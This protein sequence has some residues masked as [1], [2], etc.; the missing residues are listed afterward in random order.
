MNSNK[1]R[2]LRR[3]PSL[4]AAPDA[5][6]RHTPKECIKGRLRLKLA[7]DRSR[8]HLNSVTRRVSWRTTHPGL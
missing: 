7:E 3:R 5:L 8:P 2:A 1:I 6:S 4:L